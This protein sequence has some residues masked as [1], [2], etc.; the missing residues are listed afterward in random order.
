MKQEEAPLE[1]AANGS[2]NEGHLS[3]GPEDSR[4]G[5]LAGAV[6]ASVNSSIDRNLGSLTAPFPVSAAALG[7]LSNERTRAALADLLEKGIENNKTPA[8]EINDLEAPSA[9]QDLYATVTSLVAKMRQDA[10]HAGQDPHHHHDDEH[11]PQAVEGAKNADVAAN[12]LTS[13]LLRSSPES[14]IDPKEVEHRRQVFGT[15]A[16]ADKELDSFLKLC[17]EAVQDFVLIML[18]VL[19]LIQIVVEV[20]TLAEGENCSTC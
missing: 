16:I 5:G 10:K 14:G 15:N 20:T 12:V 6:E 2:A 3:R 1:R 17:F 13:V 19:G 11:S 7:E 18:I 4:F 8:S 9:K